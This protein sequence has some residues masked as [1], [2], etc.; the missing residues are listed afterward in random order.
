M[1]FLLL[2]MVGHSGLDLFAVAVHHERRAET[3]GDEERDDRSRQRRTEGNRGDVAFAIIEDDGITRLRKYSGSNISIVVMIQIRR[4]L[5]V[6]T[7]NDFVVKMVI[8]RKIDRLRAARRQFLRPEICGGVSTCSFSLKVNLVGEIFR[9]SENN[10]F[11]F[12][13]S[14][15]FI[16]F[17][18]NISV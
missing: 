9:S 17:L 3:E 15:L 1:R 18:I 7:E 2:R 5:T 16:R 10:I 12:I 11:K 14:I 13:M 8:C 4:N 6:D